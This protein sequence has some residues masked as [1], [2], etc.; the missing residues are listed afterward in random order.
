MVILAPVVGGIHVD[1][2]RLGKLLDIICMC[3]CIVMKNLRCLLKQI[4]PF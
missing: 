1:A 4:L 2:Q 3:D